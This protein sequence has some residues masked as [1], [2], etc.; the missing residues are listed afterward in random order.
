MSSV[1][2]TP[3]TPFSDLAALLAK[4]IEDQAR[5]S[6]VLCR[7][8]AANVPFLEDMNTNTLGNLAYLALHA[9]DPYRPR[10]RAMYDGY[11]TSAR[12][13]LHPIPPSSS[14]EAAPRS[15]EDTRPPN[16]CSICKVEHPECRSHGSRAIQRGGAHKGVFSGTTLD[17]RAPPSLERGGKKAINR[18]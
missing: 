6:D 11:V 12:S 1:A 14:E 4:P 18:D 8:N 5:Y 9:P 16:L 3:T 2:A 15:R 10:C 13:R 17:L 7:R